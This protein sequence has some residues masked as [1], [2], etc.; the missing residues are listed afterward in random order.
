MP[1]RVRY[2]DLEPRRGENPQKSGLHVL[3]DG[4][5]VADDRRGVRVVDPLREE[6]DSGIPELRVRVP[7]HVHS[8]VDERLHVHVHARL[9]VRTAAEVTPVHR[10]TGTSQFPTHSL[11]ERLA[12]LDDLR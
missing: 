3:V 7:V 12:L 1:M 9:I 10:K 4:V 2:F 11:G 8:A 6:I 5:V